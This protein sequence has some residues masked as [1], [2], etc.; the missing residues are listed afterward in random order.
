MRWA[1]LKRS[2]LTVRRCVECRS[3][4]EGFSWQRWCGTCWR[5]RMVTWHIAAAQRALAELRHA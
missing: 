1:A 5:W 4:F 3:H 2:D